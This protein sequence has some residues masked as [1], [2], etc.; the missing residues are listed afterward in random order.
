[1]HIRP[2][3]GLRNALR[4]ASAPAPAATKA[5]PLPPDRV[6]VGSSG[7]RDASEALRA[8]SRAPKA[9]PSVDG[10]LASMRPYL[11][12][13]HVVSPGAPPILGGSH[14]GRPFI[15][16]EG[17]APMPAER[18]TMTPDIESHQ[19]AYLDGL[20]NASLRA[21]DRVELEPRITRLLQRRYGHREGM[22]IAELGP[23]TST[24]VP[25]ALER[26]DH[27]YFA[28]DQS[29]PG[30][31]RNRDLLNEPGYLVSGA[32]QVRG[33]SYASPFENAC[34]DLVFTSCHPPFYSGGP[35]E[36]MEAFEE[37]SRVLKP[38][39]EFVLFPWEP[40]RH[41]DPR[42]QAFIDARFEGVERAGPRDRQ[43]RVFRKR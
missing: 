2:L 24:V 4:G 14:P 1:M 27:R 15:P 13:V 11:H 5:S 22:A 7:A 35:A 23:S 43:V 12:D 19:R 32:V 3:Q 30:L 37:V 10:L 17:V 9:P 20:S 31:E 38:G 8:A 39:G 28:L 41:D 34:L 33:D 40:D 36:R 29:L 6:A 21:Q 26:G 18:W 42:V 25:R 16:P